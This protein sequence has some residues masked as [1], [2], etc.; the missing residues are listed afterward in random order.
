MNSL[1]C[2]IRN[3]VLGI[4]FAGVVITAVGAVVWYLGV[5]LKAIG[6]FDKIEH[7]LSAGLTFIAVGSFLITSTYLFGGWLMSL[8][9]EI[10]D[11]LK[12]S[13]CK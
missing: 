11:W 12:I 2:Q 9:E 13:K 4:L 7:P 6:L 5:G 10:A 3:L 8:G 1:L